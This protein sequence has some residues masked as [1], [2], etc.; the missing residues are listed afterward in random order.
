MIVSLEISRGVDD[1]ESLNERRANPV[2]LSFHASGP[3]E[4]FAMIVQSWGLQ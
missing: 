1:P 3:L 4:R 2:I